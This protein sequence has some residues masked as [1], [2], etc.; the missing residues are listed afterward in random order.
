MA[1][2]QIGFCLGA[3]ALS[4]SLFSAPLRSVDLLLLPELVDGGYASLA[5]GNPPHT[6]MDSFVARFRR[7]SK[8]Y[9]LCCIA[10]SIRMCNKH[11]ECTNTSLSF[12]HGRLVGRYD[13]IHLFRPMGDHLYF[14]PGNTISTFGVTIGGCRVRVGVAICYDLRFPEL[15]RGMAIQ[16]LD[17]LCVP[18]RWPLNRDEAWRTLLKARAI[19]NQIFVAGCNATGVEG[20][21]SYLF[22][23][24]GEELFCNRNAADRLLCTVRADLGQ[25]REAKK[26]HNNIEEA[27]LL[28]RSRIPRRLTSRLKGHSQIPAKE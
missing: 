26:F 15:V 1:T 19:E 21:Y 16:G 22:G 9:S 6:I 2:I 7:A 20:G 28:K 3:E 8:K 13:K 17:I 12:S 10:G 14:L 5:C 25:I 24:T 23:P 11:A 18:A 27:I 4:Q